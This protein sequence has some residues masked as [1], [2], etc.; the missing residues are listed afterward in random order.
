MVGNKNATLISDGDVNGCF[1]VYTHGLVFIPLSP[2][3]VSTVVVWQPE[4]STLYLSIP[5]ME[6]LT[7]DP[8]KFQE[9]V[10]TKAPCCSGL[11]QKIIQ[12]SIGLIDELGFEAFNFGKTC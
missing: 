10:L 12:Q 11:G 2:I 4:T 3:Y 7:F 5:K 9:H 8:L 1:T 6:P